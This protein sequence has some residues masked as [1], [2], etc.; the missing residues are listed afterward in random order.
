MF[1]QAPGQSVK[2]LS[3]PRKPVTSAAGFALKKETHYIMGTILE[4]D[5]VG[6]ELNLKADIVD[7]T[8]SS[9]G[10]VEV[11]VN[12]GQSIAQ[13]TVAESEAT[14]GASAEINS[15]LS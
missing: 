8:D 12:G 4:K 6:D 10:K 3:S 11:I 1:L 9:I 7:P 15:A 13:Q 14:A 2:N 5:A